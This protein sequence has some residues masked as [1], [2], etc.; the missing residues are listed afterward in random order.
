MLSFNYDNKIYRIRFQYIFGDELNDLVKSSNIRF[1]NQHNP[2]KAITQCLLQVGNG[3]TK[4][5]KTVDVAAA[6]CNPVDQFEKERGR[7]LSLTKLLQNGKCPV[8][9]EKEFRVA[10]W[11]TYLHRKSIVEYVE[12]NN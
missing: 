7:K 12:S 1:P 3:E 11:N 4:N 10:L 5:W 9:A 8:F 6:F 2:S